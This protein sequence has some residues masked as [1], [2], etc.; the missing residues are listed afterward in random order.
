MKKFM[1]LI[2]IFCVM[3][4]TQCVAQNKLRAGEIKGNREVFVVKPA[5]PLLNQPETSIIVS[6]KRNKY[7]KGI[8]FPKDPKALPMNKKTDMK[9]DTGAIR[10]IVFNI[11]SKKLPL[12]KQNHEKLAI[13]LIFEPSGQLTDV[14]FVLNKNTAITAEELERID[15]KLREDIKAKFSGKYYLNEV[16]MRR[17]G[18]LLEYIF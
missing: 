7:D 8:P 16:A 4:L 9:V 11:L 2:L 6:S 17:P 10:V 14:G 1:T 15:L 5:T 12:L 18:G 3:T 13:D